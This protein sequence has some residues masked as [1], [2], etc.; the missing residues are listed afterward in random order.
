MT[1][2]YQPPHT[3]LHNAYA[4]INGIHWYVYAVTHQNTTGRH[5]I[6]LHV[7]RVD[8]EGQNISITPDTLSKKVQ[9]NHLRPLPPIPRGEYTCKILKNLPKEFVYLWEC[10][11]KD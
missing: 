3:F 9:S 5:P 10:P 2:I 1:K 6:I 7:G 11:K 4:D 8:K